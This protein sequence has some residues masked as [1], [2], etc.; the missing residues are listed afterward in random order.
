[1]TQEGFEPTIHDQMR[2]QEET[3]MCLESQKN[4]RY[5]LNFL[6]WKMEMSYHFLK[7]KVISISPLYQ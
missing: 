6:Y 4:T 1:M 5:G 2:Y 7:T 3:Q